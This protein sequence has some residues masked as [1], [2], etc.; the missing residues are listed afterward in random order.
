MTSLTDLVFAPLGV[1][2]VLILGA[3][4]LLLLDLALPA[5]KKSAVVWGAVVIVLGA[6][7]LTFAGEERFSLM[8]AALGQTYVGD[9]FGVL[10][11]RVMLGAALLSLL[12]SIRFLD[13]EVPGRQ[14]EYVQLLLFSLAGMTLL[15]GVRDL[16]LLLVAFELMGIPL[17]V[18]AAYQKE[19]KKG[20]EGALKLYLVGAVSSAILMFG[21]T[22]LFGLAG[23]TSLIDIGSF[24][25]MGTTPLFLVGATLLIAG[26]GFKLGLFP[27][28]MWVPDTYE[29]AATPYV[30][31][32]SIAPKAAG[33]IALIQVLFTADR[34]LLDALFL[35]LLLLAVTT[36]V[37]GNLL[38]LPQSNVKRLLGYSGVA[39][40]GFFIMAIACGTSEGL[41]ALLFYLVAYLGSNAGAF[42]VIHAV[43]GASMERF[44]GLSRRDGLLGMAM[45]LFMLSLGGIPFVAGFWAKLYV[46]L[47][48]WGAGL[49]GL[50]VL[51][52]A[53]SV[54]G[55]FYYLKVCRAMYMNMPSSD[56][57]LE[58][59]VFTRLGIILSLAV[60][61]VF[62]V[63]PGPLVDAADLAASLLLNSLS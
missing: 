21:A 50:V 23:S 24:A 26:M 63:W 16:L 30:T 34:A 11:K 40:M 49:E 44:D 27:F 48:A 7:L 19:E 52:A 46:F 5:G 45:L 58:V 57:P 22:L 47:A 13:T 1:E 25:A 29:G 32:L 59:D 56:E 8:G 37:A 33:L 53:M 2:L 54:V 31:F 17:Y 10:A 3:F 43:G 61:V 4:V 15:T 35:L 39:H 12:G 18:L 6:L 36:L 51:G 9:A 20:V 62:G 38:A 42:L 14:G 41:A 55:L 28:H 60:I